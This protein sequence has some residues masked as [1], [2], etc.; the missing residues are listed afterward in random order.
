MDN[1]AFDLLIVPVLWG[2]L[3]SLVAG[4]AIL[5]VI[6]TTAALVSRRPLTAVGQV[7][8]SIRSTQSAS[9]ASGLRARGQVNRLDTTL[10]LMDG[11]RTHE[12]CRR[13]GGG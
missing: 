5:G 8:C 9:R 12:P 11:D 7:A 4:A 13:A 1:S 6:N 10:S 3:G 2:T